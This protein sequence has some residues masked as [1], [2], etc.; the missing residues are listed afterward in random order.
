VG[1]LH[2]SGGT[3]GQVLATDGAGNLSWA[4]AGGGASLPLANGTS[5]VNIPAINGNVTIS[6]AGNANIFTVTGT[7]ANVTGTLNVTGNLVSANISSGN[8]AATGQIITS[9]NIQGNNVTSS[10]AMTVG[11]NL[12]VFG[13][14]NLNA[15]G[16]VTITGGTSGQV[17]TTNGSGVLSWATPAAAP[18]ANGTSTV[19]IPVINGNVEIKS[20]SNTWAFANTG[21]LNT[22]TGAETQILA[23]NADLTIR[24][25]E[26]VGSRGTVSLQSANN[27][28][29][30]NLFSSF[31]ATTLKAVITAYAGGS[32][33]GTARNWEF[34]PEGGLVSPVLTVGTMPF[35]EPGKRA[36]ASDSSLTAT[37]NFGASVIGQGG[38]PFT[39][40]VWS[41]GT[42]WYIG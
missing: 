26:T 19:S 7:G 23:S 36:F 28:T 9:N 6:A 5:N 12:Q 38:G 8:I 22:P 10:N 32:A 34:Q 25:I 35:P 4:T 33:S 30:N 29:A 20:G 13:K 24:A 39:V 17:L 14:S 3:S 27:F 37:N 42:D 31:T 15:V 41:D 16:N 2:I 18:L 1:N 11:A 21:I 40:P